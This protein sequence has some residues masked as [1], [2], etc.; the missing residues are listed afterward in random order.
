[1]SVQHHAL[2]V[3]LQQAVAR[4]APRSRRSPAPS[5]TEAGA[6]RDQAL[7][8]R[9]A[10]TR[11]PA[12]RDA[13][14]QRY[15]PLARHAAQHYARPREPFD[16]LLQI[17]S[18]GLLKAI[19]RYDPQLGTAFA[20]YAIPTMHGDLRRHFRDRSWAVR[21]PRDLQELALRVERVA[22]ELLTT[23]GRAPTVQQLAEHT[24]LSIEAVLEARQALCA[25][26]AASLSAPS[27]DGDGPDVAARLGEVDRGYDDVEHRAT[28]EE[29]MRCLTRRER[30]IVRLRLQEDL[31]QL[32]IGRRLGLSQMH[33]SRLLRA[34]LA[35][36]RAEAAPP[37][38]AA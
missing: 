12:L 24:G 17:A 21:P 34:S 30:E 13:L 16:D 20:S 11:D 14:V 19:D 26:T 27:S 33:V 4:S 6:A 36:L 7:L 28:L 37:G 31:T 3:R 29:L 15:L 5:R 23:L 8:A 25:H 18:I 32:E 22:T 9:Y 10:A 1:M 2:D 35:K 38:I